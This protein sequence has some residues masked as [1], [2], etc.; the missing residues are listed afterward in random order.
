MPPTAPPKFAR[1]DFNRCLGSITKMLPVV[2]VAL[3][4]VVASRS[5]ARADSGDGVPG[6]AVLTPSVSQANPA[7]VAER[8]RLVTDIRDFNDLA[9]QFNVDCSS[10]DEENANAVQSCRNRQGSLRMQKDDLVT[11]IGVFNSNVR[12]ARANLTPAARASDTA[13]IRLR[14]AGIQNA[15][16]QL[17]KAMSLDAFQRQEWEEE[18][19]RASFEAWL[20]AGSLALKG[21]SK[22]VDVA[23]ETN[24]DEII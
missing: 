13:F 15:L 7:L 19:A 17:N 18:S 1:L 16:R 9:R 8:A 2:L 12:T 20:M 5:I 23:I 24:V 22:A 14:I 6:L 11:R 21:V 10:V 4:L 3:A